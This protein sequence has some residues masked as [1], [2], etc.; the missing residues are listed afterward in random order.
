MSSTLENLLQLV[1]NNA[2]DEIVHNPAIPN[3][4]NEAAIGETAGHI[5]EGLKSQVSDGNI[6]GLMGL[7]NG[8]TNNLASNPIV[9][10]IITSLANTFASKFGIDP[11]QAISVANPLITKVMG[12]LI[13]KIN[14]P[15]DSQFDL[16]TL[17]KEF[18]GGG[19]GGM[20]GGML[21]GSGGGL[22]GKM[23]G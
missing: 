4:F 3:Q 18:G 7:L 5:V 14:D 22:L 20:L 2:S 17:A 9:S 15:N 11:Q 10:Q 12:L 6:G 1:Q 16:G 19:L 23:F 21:G 13:S 8:G